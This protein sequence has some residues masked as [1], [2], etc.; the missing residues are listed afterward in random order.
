MD[1]AVSKKGTNEVSVKPKR[2]IGNTVIFLNTLCISCCILSTDF[3]Y[4]NKL[5]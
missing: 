3:I 5:I 2:N 1:V 4:T